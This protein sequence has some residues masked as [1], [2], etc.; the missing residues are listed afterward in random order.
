MSDRS[1]YSGSE[2]EDNR[3]HSDQDSDNRDESGSE[4]GDQSDGQCDDGD[5][6]PGEICEPRV[7]TLVSQIDYKNLTLCTIPRTSLVI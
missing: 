2:S 7:L 6:E 5:V 3:S 1:G 4:Y